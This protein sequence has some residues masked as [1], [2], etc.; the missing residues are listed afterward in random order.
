MGDQFP[1]WS[2]RGYLARLNRSLDG[3][4]RD[5]AVARF[6]TT[7]RA[8][9]TVPWS[10]TTMPGTAATGG[11]GGGVSGW[12]AALDH[13][14]RVL[15]I[16]GGV[17]VALAFLTLVYDIVLL[18]YGCLVGEGP[19]R[20]RFLF[21]RFVS[22]LARHIVR[23]LRRAAPTPSRRSTE[24]ATFLRRRRAERAPIVEVPPSDE[25]DEDVVLDVER[26]LRLEWLLAKVVPALVGWG[27]FPAS[28]FLLLNLWLI[29]CKC[30][31]FHCTRYI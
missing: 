11:G 16:V 30:T 9:V 31:G 19:A 17:L 14:T 1:A 7:S 13:E 21:A 29:A 6:S 2:F 26:Q 5:R 4:L 18:V 15:L 10:L 20:P 8:S 12:F 28:L 23:M 27:S 22:Y 24:R 25:S 3:Y